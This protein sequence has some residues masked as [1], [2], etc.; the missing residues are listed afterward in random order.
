MRNHALFMPWS[1]KE[2]PMKN[3]AKTVALY[4]L[5]YYQSKSLIRG[6]CKRKRPFSN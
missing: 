1:R 6:I 4:E 5:Q 2:K 3:I